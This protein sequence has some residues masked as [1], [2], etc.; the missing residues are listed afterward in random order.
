MPLISYEDNKR[1]KRR[2]RTQQRKEKYGASY[3]LGGADRKK[4]KKDKLY[5][6]QGRRCAWCDKNMTYSK[7]TIDHIVRVTDGGTGSMENLQLLHRHCHD[8]KEQKYDRK[9]KMAKKMTLN[10]SALDRIEWDK[11]RKEN[12][13]TTKE[14]EGV[15]QK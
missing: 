2:E 9:K 11:I 5:K 13:K 12:D 1:A 8:K 6:R 10:Q 4:E 3:T 7:A 14:N 15:A